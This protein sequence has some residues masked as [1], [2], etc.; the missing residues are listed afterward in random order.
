MRSEGG[1]V[2]LLPPRLGAAVPRVSTAPP[3][4]SFRAAP[5]PA[6]GTTTPH[7]CCH[8]PCHRRRLVDQ[9]EALSPA[10]PSLFHCASLTVK[11]PVRF[12]AGVAIRGDVTLINGEPRQPSGC[13]APALCKPA[14][15]V[16]QTCV[17]G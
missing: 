3:V 14:K 10:V 6:P 15:L 4:S 16:N 9:L 12:E 1:G 7:H 2:K 11:G 8:L 17:A 13:P 5:R